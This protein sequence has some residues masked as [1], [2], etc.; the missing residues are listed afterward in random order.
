M[1]EELKKGDLIYS[2]E[3]STFGLRSVSLYTYRV[4]RVQGRFAKCARIDRG[5]TRLATFHKEIENGQVQPRYEGFH[6]TRVTA[7]V[8]EESARTFYETERLMP[9]T[10]DRDR[11][12]SWI[13]KEAP[14]GL[15]R[16]LEKTAKAWKEAEEKKKR[17]EGEAKERGGAEERRSN[18]S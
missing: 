12:A 7:F 9:N 16:E 15:V 17:A 3:I 2:V 8:G 14:P 1:P 11:I 10:C 13:L 6:S 18:D 4:G 5:L